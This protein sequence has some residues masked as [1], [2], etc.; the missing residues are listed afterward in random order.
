MINICFKKFVFFLGGQVLESNF[1][2]FSTDYET[3]A[4]ISNCDKEIRD[5]ELHFSQHASLWSRT[6]KLGYNFVDNVSPLFNTQ[7]TDQFLCLISSILAL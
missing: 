7:F 5:G 1:T 3:Y 4:V 6:P 2:V